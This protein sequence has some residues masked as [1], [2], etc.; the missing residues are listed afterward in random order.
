[1]TDIIFFII[2]RYNVLNDSTRGISHGEE[3]YCDHM[4]NVWNRPTSPDWSGD[5]WYRIMSE[6]GTS[7][8]EQSPGMSHCGTAIPAWI[9]DTVPNKNGHLKDVKVCMDWD[10]G[11][12]DCFQEIST[13]V[14]KCLDFIVYYLVN[15][16]TCD[17]RYCTS[18]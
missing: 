13:G 16:P 15:T 18:D 11:D 9:N 1:M 14:T 7:I 6:A 12:D 5:G 10:I 17:V 8:P 4:D 2:C 3:D